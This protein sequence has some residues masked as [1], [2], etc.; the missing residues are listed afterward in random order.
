L[1]QDNKAF[2]DGFW[3][4]ATSAPALGVALAA[5]V[6]LAVNGRYFM[7]LFLGLATACVTMLKLSKNEP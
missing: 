2:W 5:I 7:A 4:G 6:F 1:K 3:D